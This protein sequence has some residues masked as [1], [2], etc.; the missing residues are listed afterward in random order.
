MTIDGLSYLIQNYKK[1][2]SILQAAYPL[3][4]AGDTQLVKSNLVSFNSGLN[5]IIHQ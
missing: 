4:P 2:D 1:L 5:K 3:V